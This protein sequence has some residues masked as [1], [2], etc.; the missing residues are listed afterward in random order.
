MFNRP[1]TDIHLTAMELA[2]WICP[3]SR[4]WIER[5]CSVSYALDRR[6]P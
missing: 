1:I 6:P 4:T 2:G 3:I 5:Q